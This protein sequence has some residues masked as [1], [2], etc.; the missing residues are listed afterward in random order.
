M[1]PGSCLLLIFCMK[2]ITCHV[3]PYYRHVSLQ[4]PST[5]IFWTFC[6]SQ[7][8][9]FSRIFL[10]HGLRQKNFAHSVTFPA[11]SARQTTNQNFDAED[12]GELPKGSFKS[13]RLMMVCL[14]DFLCKTQKPPIFHDLIE[15]FH[16]KSLPF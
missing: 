10:L 11:F 12:K 15:F 9:I 14:R 2:I 1:R 5:A 8:G 4:S 7:R 3:E 13:K 16:A 6:E